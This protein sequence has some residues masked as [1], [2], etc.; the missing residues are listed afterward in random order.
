MIVVPGVDRPCNYAPGKKK[1]VSLYAVQAGWAR[2]K[3][4]GPIPPKLLLLFLENFACRPTRY[5]L[6]TQCPWSRDLVRNSGGVNL[7]LRLS[8]AFATISLRVDVTI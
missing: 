7:H 3:E 4:Q 8:V 2:H 5:H 6:A 1:C